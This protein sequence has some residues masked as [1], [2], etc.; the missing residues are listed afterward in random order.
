MIRILS[1]VASVTPSITFPF[2]KLEFIVPDVVVAALTD[3][4]TFK[5]SAT[6]STYPL[7]AT[8]LSSVGS[9]IL[10]IFTVVVSSAPENFNS[11]VVPDTAEIL[12]RIVSE[13]LNA[14]LSLLNTAVAIILY[15]YI[16]V[17]LSII[18]N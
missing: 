18:L 8:S 4:L 5:P 10:V 13:L 9:L 11:F 17:I 1:L 2:S 6:E 3:F 15:I 12:A 7:F 16:L 14:I